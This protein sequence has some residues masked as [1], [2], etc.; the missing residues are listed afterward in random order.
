MN[1]LCLF[2]MI[3]I[4]CSCNRKPEE[5]LVYDQI[6]D[7]EISQRIEMIRS[8]GA[9]TSLH[10]DS[11]PDPMLIQKEIDNMILLS[12]DME[13]ADAVIQKAN[14]YFRNTVQKY[15]VPYEGFVV[16]IKTMSLPTIETAIKT[17]QLN[18]L[19]KIIFARIKLLNDSTVMGSVY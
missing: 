10:T 13:N 12:K 8:A 6:V 15:G 9:D 1:K 17:N 18:L 2:F 3:L 19:D 7:A 16:L 5:K 4:I 14:D 11:L